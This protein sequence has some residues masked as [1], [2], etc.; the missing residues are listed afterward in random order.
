MVS[1][2]FKGEHTSPLRAFFLARP[3]VDKTYVVWWVVYGI[4]FVVYL[5][6]FI[7]MLCLFF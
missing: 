5:G 2:V 7:V 6:L 3:E 4:G 1:N